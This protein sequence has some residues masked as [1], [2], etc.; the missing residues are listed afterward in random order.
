MN[1]HGK[2]TPSGFAD[3]MTKGKSDIFGKTA[4]AYA[5]RIILER[6]GVEVPEVFAKALD[7]GNEWEE[8]AITE[9]E[10]QTGSFVEPTSV[11]EHPELNFVAGTPDGLV[12][13]DGMIEVKCPFNPAN[14]LENLKSGAQIED[15][16]YQIQGYLW[17]TG[18]KWCD[19]VSYDPR[20]PEQFRLFV[21]RVH[22]DQ[23][24]IDAIKDRCIQ[25]ENYIQSMLQFINP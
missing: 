13:E 21:R 23:V 2:I 20:F 7:H 11:I 15:Y 9:Y 22:R 1:K 8:Y 10:K 25:F 16:K 3:M 12:G 5:N 19:F 14:H 6:I 4:I 17:I 24:L 18:R